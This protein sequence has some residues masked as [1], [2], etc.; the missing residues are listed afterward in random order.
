MEPQSH[1]QH[2]S[3]KYET[4]MVGKLISGLSALSLKVTLSLA[5]LHPFCP[6][7]A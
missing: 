3:L 5:A 4:V 7:Q 2:W 6:W 1:L